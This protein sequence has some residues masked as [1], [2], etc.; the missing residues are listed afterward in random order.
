MTIKEFYEF[1]VSRDVQNY[2]LK[3]RDIDSPEFCFDIDQNEIELD[4]ENYL[5]LV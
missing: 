3:V 4:D 1:C 5:V 2:E